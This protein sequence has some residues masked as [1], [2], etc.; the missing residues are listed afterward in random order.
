MVAQTGPVLLNFSMRRTVHLTRPSLQS[1]EPVR[2]R[3]SGLGREHF[4]IF[5]ELSCLSVGLP[6]LRAVVLF[7]FVQEGGGSGRSRLPLPF[8]KARAGRL[9][10]VALMVLTGDRLVD[11]QAAQ[12]PF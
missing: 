6:L 8:R 4:Y 11:D 9:R 7:G 3:A 10:S 5:P 2:T 12:E 1:V